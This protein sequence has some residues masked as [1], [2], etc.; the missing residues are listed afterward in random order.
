MPVFRIVPLTCESEDVQV[1]ALDVPDVSLGVPDER[2]E[3]TSDENQPED[4]LNSNIKSLFSKMR[5]SCATEQLCDVV[6]DAVQSILES[7]RSFVLQQVEDAVSSHKASVCFKVAEGLVDEEASAKKRLIKI[8]N[9]KFY[10]PAREICVGR[11]VKKRSRDSDALVTSEPLTAYWVPVTETLTGKNLNYQQGSVFSKS[12]LL[13][14][15]GRKYNKI[16]ISI[17]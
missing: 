1:E 15:F 3:A 12:D 17:I 16:K 6:N 2:I 9:S 5:A 14:S 11:E 4:Q 13:E 7:L 10:V 8:Q